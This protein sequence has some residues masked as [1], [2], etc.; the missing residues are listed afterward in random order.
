MFN[1]NTN[2]F[3][4]NQGTGACYDFFFSH[5]T[6]KNFFFRVVKKKKIVTSP[7][8]QGALSS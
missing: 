7:C 2:N 1:T 5:S 4:A 3:I 8:D 6:L